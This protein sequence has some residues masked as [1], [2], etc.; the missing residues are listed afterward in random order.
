MPT[1]DFSNSSQLY[2]TTPHPGIPRDREVSEYERG[3][4]ASLGDDL[5]EEQIQRA[6]RTHRE[7]IQRALREHTERNTPAGPS[8]IP[9]AV[10]ERRLA[11]LSEREAVIRERVSALERYRQYETERLDARILAQIEEMRQEGSPRPVD[12]EP[13]PGAPALQYET[14]LQVRLHRAQGGVHEGNHEYR[15]S[16]NKTLPTVEDV[17]IEPKSVWE[18]LKEPGL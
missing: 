14:T 9:N 18:W 6:L 8:T 5:T 3:L 7:R 1:D 10:L 12:P 16:M 13:I 17:V 15:V 11:E 2:R 4:R